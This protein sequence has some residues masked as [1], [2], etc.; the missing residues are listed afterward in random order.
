M[1]SLGRLSLVVIALLC[2]AAIQERQPDK[3]PPSGVPANAKLFNRKWYVV[4]LETVPWDR[5]KAKCA[6]LGGQLTV[7]PDARTWAFIRNLAGDARVWLG[8]T[9]EVTQGVW[10]WVDGSPITFKAWLPGQ[11]DSA[12][13]GQ[14]HYLHIHFAPGKAHGWNDATNDGIINERQHVVGYICEWKDQ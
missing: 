9:D 3:T 13:N 11:P 6:E 7:V 1:K 2:M 12:K 14:E 8:A 5:A 10:K 4:Y